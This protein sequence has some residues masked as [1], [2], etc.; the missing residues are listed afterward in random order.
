MSKVS[1]GNEALTL[2]HSVLLYVPE[3]VLLMFKVY[4]PNLYFKLLGF[5]ELLLFPLS[6]Y[7][8]GREPRSLVYRR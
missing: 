4:H 8:R 3:S 5:T 2:R 7:I 1:I 6:T